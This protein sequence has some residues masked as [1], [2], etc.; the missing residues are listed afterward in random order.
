MFYERGIVE[1][2]WITATLAWLEK[3]ILPALL[4]VRVIPKP[5]DDRDE[6]VQKALMLALTH[7]SRRWRDAFEALH[8]DDWLSPP[9]AAHLAESILVGIFIEAAQA[10]LS[11]TPLAQF[12]TIRLVLVKP[13]R[14]FSMGE[15]S[16]EAKE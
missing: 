8:K 6:V 7:R 4:E 12:A 16:A 1:P 11:G 14:P 9:E 2:G 13:Y 5:P 10:A 15:T 3:E